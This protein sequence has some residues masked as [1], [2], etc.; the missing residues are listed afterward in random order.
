L[1]QQDPTFKRMTSDDILGRIINHEMLIEEVK[2]V[3]NLSKGI[4]SS[5]KHDIA[6]KD[7]KKG[8]SKKV[9]EEISNEEEGDDDESTEYD[10]DEMTLFI[11][12]FSKVMS[13]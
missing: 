1:I 4:T 10:P 12:R 2:H 7:S 3:K 8:K 11:R 5:I 13:K 6:F 9:V